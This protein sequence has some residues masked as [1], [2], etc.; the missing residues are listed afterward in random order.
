[1]D[2]I[3]ENFS[4][5]EIIHES[6]RRRDMKQKLKNSKVSGAHILLT[7]DP[8]SAEYK[9]E[10]V[11]QIDGSMSIEGMPLTEADKERIRNF[12]FDITQ[13]DK[14]VASLVKKHCVTR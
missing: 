10:I 11:R 8:I 9:E 2:N 5:D 7:D 4:L 14:V 12:A 3:S 6:E 13:I 1:M